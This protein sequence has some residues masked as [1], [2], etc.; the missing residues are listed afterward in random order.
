MST[1]GE[2]QK[3]PKGAGERPGLRRPRFAQTDRAL[4]S[5]GPPREA[6]ERRLVRKQGDIS[7]EAASARAR[8]QGGARRERAGE[9]QKHLRALEERHGLLVV[10]VG[11]RRPREPLLRVLGLP[12]PHT[13][14]GVRR[15]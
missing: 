11:E 8:G 9:G 4:S 7:A 13:G 14:R 2:G 3:H 1:H 15:A 10:V 12:P 5:G 6:S